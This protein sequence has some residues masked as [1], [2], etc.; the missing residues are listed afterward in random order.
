MN[1]NHTEIQV[2]NISK[3]DNE[4]TKLVLHKM[5][6]M[7]ESRLK[8][9]NIFVPVILT[10]ITSLLAYFFKESFFDEIMWGVLFI[11]A[12]LLLCFISIVIAYFPQR[13]Y[14]FNA[15]KPKWIKRIYKIDTF[16]PWNMDSICTLSDEDFITKFQEY[17][18]RDLTKEELLEAN[19]LK[20]K[21]NELNY[22]RYYISTC[23][24]IIIIG[25]V[26]LAL[27][28][29]VLAIVSYLMKI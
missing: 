28:I 14:R 21:I 12:Y 23:F 25:A 11:I 6:E 17:L 16:I 24:K 20:Q 2:D 29:T 8:S 9:M 15:N 1:N 5:T 4:Y 7:V 27:L 18:E 22:K 19:C 13:C 26:I 3:H 10:I